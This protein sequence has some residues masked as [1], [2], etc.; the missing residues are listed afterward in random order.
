MTSEVF[1]RETRKAPKQRDYCDIAAD[2]IQ[3]P[4][5]PGT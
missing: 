4:T 3:T 2:T 5:S 1:S